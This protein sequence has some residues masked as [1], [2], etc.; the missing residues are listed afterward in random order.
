[1]PSPTTPRCVR[2]RC[3]TPERPGI[4]CHYPVVVAFGERYRVIHTSRHFASPKQKDT[5]TM[6]TEIPNREELDAHFYQF[7]RDV[8][9]FN[10][11]WR[12]VR[13]EYP[14]QY[15]AVYKGEIVAKHANLKKLLAA[16]DAKGISGRHAVVRFTRSKDR[17]LIL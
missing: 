3:A 1:M 9:Y 17:P 15:I 5:L 12:Q 11:I 7:G 13:Q 4:L 6:T 14:E 16:L 2:A 8:D 10:S